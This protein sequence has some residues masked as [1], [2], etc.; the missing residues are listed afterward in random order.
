[1]EFGLLGPL[2]VVDRGRPL[3]F[4]RG[5]HRALLALLLLHANEVV[6]T[7]RL[8]DDLWGEAPPPTAAKIVRNYVSSLRKALGAEEGLLQTHAAGYC[9]A[10]GEAT[11]DLEQFEQLVESGRRSLEKGDAIRAA[12]VLREALALWRGPP[13]A[14]FTYETFAQR[15]IARLEELR[16]GALEERIEADLRLGRHAELVPELESLVS[17]YPLRERL[18]EQLMLALYRSGRQLTRSLR[19]RK[20]GARSSMSWDSSLDADCKSSSVGSWRRTAHSSRRQPPSAGAG[21][22]SSVR[23]AVAF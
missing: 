1:M 9:L 11:L 7:S 10:L 13:L 12:A 20:G 8:I 15:E 19:T 23:A 6:S 16:L 22:L 3:A 5:K 21:R 14:D 18:R 4:G 2:E 17:E